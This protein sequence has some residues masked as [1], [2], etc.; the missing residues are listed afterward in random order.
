MSVYNE[1]Q[2]RKREERWVGHWC[3]TLTAIKAARGARESSDVAAEERVRVD[4]YH[5]VT[6]A[7]GLTSPSLLAEIKLT[8]MATA[9]HTQKFDDHGLIARLRHFYFGEPIDYTRGPLDE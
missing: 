5:H 4:A 3:D 9:A 1:Q 8:A 6:I 7:R 2:R